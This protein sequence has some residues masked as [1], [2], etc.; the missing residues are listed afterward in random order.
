MRAAREHLPEDDADQAEAFV[1]Q[2]YRWVAPDDLAERSPLDVYGAALAHFNLARQRRP[3]A[4]PK[5][6]VYNPEFDVDGWQ[7][8]H[9]AVEIVTDDMPFLIDSVTMELNRRGYGV[10]LMIHPVIGV[11]RD[12]E[13]RLLE[14]L[15]P[16][17]APTP[18]DAIS[19]SVIH[20]EVDRQ[21]DPAELTAIEEPPACA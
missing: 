10:H 7:S 20:A 4:T 6:R 8:T 21:T 14:V 19:E 1:R 15:A 12:E 2:Y 13:G 18:T 17:D 5:V 9:T 3:R 11:R 16:G